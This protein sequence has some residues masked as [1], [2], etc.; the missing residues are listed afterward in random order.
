MGKVVLGLM[1]CVGP[2]VASNDDVRCAALPEREGWCGELI[3]GRPPAPRPDADRRG[4]ANAEAATSARGSSGSPLPDMPGDDVDI[5][6]GAWVCSRRL[7]LEAVGTT[8][9][10]V[11]ARA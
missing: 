4:E 10:G 1:S 11:A 2:V 6:T 9:S 5:A 7:L 8:G 3:G